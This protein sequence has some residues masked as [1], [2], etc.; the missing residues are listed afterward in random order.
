MYDLKEL[1]MSPNRPLTKEQY[2]DF[3]KYMAMT[4]YDK[5]AKDVDISLAIDELVMEIN[6]RKSYWW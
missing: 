5:S 1:L 2:G 3:D 6:E 4:S